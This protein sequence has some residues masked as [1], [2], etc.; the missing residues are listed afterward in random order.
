MRPACVNT[1]KPS[2]RA[3]ATSVMPAA[4]ATRSASAGGADTA[5]QGDG[6][7]GQAL[8]RAHRMADELS[9]A[10]RPDTPH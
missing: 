6:G 8:E 2:S 7:P 10:G 1:S 9:G 5:T 3:I 4:S